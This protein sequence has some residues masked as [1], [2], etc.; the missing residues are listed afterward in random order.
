MRYR[1]PQGRVP[2]GRC[3][4]NAVKSEGSIRVSMRI[5]GR[6]VATVGPRVVERGLVQRYGVGRTDKERLCGLE[7]DVQRGQCPVGR[8]PAGAIKIKRPREERGLARARRGGHDHR[9]LLQVALTPIYDF[10]H[11]DAEI[12][13]EWK[14]AIVRKTHEEVPRGVAR[15]R[16]SPIARPE[17]IRQY[18]AAVR[19]G[20]TADGAAKLRHIRN[21][22]HQGRKSEAGHIDPPGA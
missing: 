18:R 22:V 5:D 15:P 2:R 13:I 12:A 1:G 19:V 6:A 21:R 20:S 7:S 4:Q 9:A 10:D 3:V 14:T 8:A 17:G 11:A 16:M